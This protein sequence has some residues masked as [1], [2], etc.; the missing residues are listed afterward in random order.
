ML[1]EFAYNVIALAVVID[2]IGT[3][4][5]F[6]GLTRG[7]T[8]E[9]RRAMA[10]RGTLIAAFLILFFAFAGELLLRA[11][12]VS[13]AAFEIAG[14]ALLFL[15][16]T[17]MVFARQSGMRH[18]TQPEADEARESEDISV[19]PL[20]IPL[21]AGPGA[22]TSIVILMREADGSTGAQAA[23]IGALAVVMVGTYVCLAAAARI[24]SLLGVTGTNVVS[25]VLGIILAALATELLI[26]GI[27]L[28]LGS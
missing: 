1:Q 28:S 3:A 16:A 20:G 24:V 8:P 22:L 17:E 21:L 27:R 23:V 19:F 5:V 18:T 11:M 7:A 25:R 4:A 9:H 13:L 10:R 14:G 6:M 15:L 26:G 2:P 12:G